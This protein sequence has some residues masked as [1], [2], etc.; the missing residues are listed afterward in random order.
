[1]HQ[2]SLYHRLKGSLHALRIPDIASLLYDAPDDEI[3]KV[4][5]A[6]AEIRKRVDPEAHE[7]FDSNLKFM[8]Q[9]NLHGL[10][11][12]ETLEIMFLGGSIALTP[13]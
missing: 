9:R 6:A 12:L 2:K 1:M 13:D 4:L 3:E 11:I 10:Y 7:L 5:P 8:L